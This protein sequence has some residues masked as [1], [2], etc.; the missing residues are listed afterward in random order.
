MAAA[1]TI[2]GPGYSVDVPPGF[3]LA[4]SIPMAGLFRWLPPGVSQFN[5]DAMVQVRSVQP[6]ELQGLLQALYSLENPMVAMQQCMS[7]GL[8]GLLGIQPARQVQMAQG[9]SHIREFDAMN[10]LGIP[11]RVMVVIM[12]SQQ[13][14]VEV[15][16]A[17]TLYNWAQYTAPC[18]D[19]LSRINLAGVQQPPQQ[20]VAVVD[21]ERK[22]QVE[23][24]LVGPN[25]EPV[26]LT[27]LPTN[28][29]G[30]TI[31]NVDTL[32]QTGNI[33]GTGIAVGSH[34]VA[35]VDWDKAS[36]NASVHS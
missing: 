3:T 13:A 17:I 16:V 36:D 14:A 20:V 5:V 24:R 21:K 6:F 10:Y 23:Y 26:T 33:N 31:I 19:F 9:P 35:K 4:A 22:D 34:S 8:A 25:G 32:I 18:M 30:T 1:N 12:T 11:L 7:M 2:F 15:L 29:G 28:V 27:A